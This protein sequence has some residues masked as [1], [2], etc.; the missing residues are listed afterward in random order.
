MAGTVLRNGPANEM[1]MNESVF[2]RN[3]VPLPD[4]RTSFS[5]RSIPTRAIF[6]TSPNRDDYF[7][8]CSIYAMIDGMAMSNISATSS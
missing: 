4:I 6:Q 8:V 2:G 5:L 1:R 7:D 3:G